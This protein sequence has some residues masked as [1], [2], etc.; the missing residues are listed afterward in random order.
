MPV[1]QLSEKAGFE[2]EWDGDEKRVDAYSEDINVTLYIDITDVFVEKDGKEARVESILPPKII[3]SVTYVPLRTV[4]EA[5]GA[6]VIWDGEKNIIHIYMGEEYE[7]VQEEV[8]ET[9]TPDNAGESAKS[10]FYSQYD[11]EYVEKYS[12]EPYGWTAGRNGYCYVTSYAM[13]LSDITGTTITPI[14]IADINISAGGTPKVCYHGAI[15]G[16][17]GKRLVQALDSGSSYFKSY[18]SGRGLTYIDNSTEEN[19]IAAIKEALDRNPLGVMVR[20]LS[21]PHT[22]VAVRYEGDTIYFN[23]PALERGEVT[24]EETCLKKQSITTLV[25][26]MAIQ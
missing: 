1:R 20:D 19:V 23:D 11:E 8:K 4:S 7:N 2:I 21:M 6:K 10:T 14:E 22:M 12:E 16:K 26:I 25:A 17:Y 13:L 5:F 15:V 18:D 9:E 24:W 3:N